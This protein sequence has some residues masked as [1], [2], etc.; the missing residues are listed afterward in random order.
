MAIKL[1][2]KEL[3]SAVKLLETAANLGQRTNEARFYLAVALERL[4]QSRR[5]L[6]TYLAVRP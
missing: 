1:E 2:Q 5:A 4:G 6:D 3:E